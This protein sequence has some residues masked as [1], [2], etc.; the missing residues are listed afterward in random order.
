MSLFIYI[1]IALV[2]LTF[3]ALSLSGLQEHH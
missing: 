3:V 2:L 1:I